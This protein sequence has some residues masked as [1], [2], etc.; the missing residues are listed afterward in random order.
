M[1]GVMA[2]VI[3]LFLVGFFF[4]SLLHSLRVCMRVYVGASLPL[5]LSLF[6]FVLHYYA[7]QYLTLGRTCARRMW[8]ELSKCVT[9]STPVSSL[10]AQ[11]ATSLVTERFSWEHCL[12][13]FFG[14]TA[15]YVLTPMLS[16]THGWDK[17]SHLYYLKRANIPFIGVKK[18]KKYNHNR[19]LSSCQKQSLHCNKDLMTGVKK[20]NRLA[21]KPP[22]LVPI[23]QD[24]INIIALVPKTTLY[25][26]A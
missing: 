22:K 1:L 20:E 5:S 12:F 2:A 23:S 21:D 25:W 26:F 19:L 13:S 4:P 16:L 3:I 18:A 6:F 8:R 10:T 9:I 7:M 14:C 11:L 17:G 15:L 24:D